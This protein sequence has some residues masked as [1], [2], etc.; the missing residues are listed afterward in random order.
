MDKKIL[1]IGDSCRDIF[2]YC[3]AERLCPD[4]PVPVLNIIDQTEN[5]GMA[6][7][8]QRNIQ[9]LIKECDIVTNYN[10]Y[11]ITKTRYMHKRT[12]HMFFRIDANQHEVPRINIKNLNLDYKIVVVSDYNKGFL[13]EEDIEYICSS[14]SA[15]FLDTK[16]NVG[17]F[18]NKALYIKINHHEYKCSE[19]TLT[20]KLANKI[21]VT[22]GDKGCLFREK[23]YP[24][25]KVQVWDLSGAGDSFMAGLVC[26]YYETN[27]IETSIIFANKCASKV[28]QERGVS[29]I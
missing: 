27:D 15:V 20:K 2:I 8:V 14:H 16:K 6:K 5:A 1:V 13:T 19:P 25:K 21:I 28:V 29:I 17:S 4:I 24:V 12:N 7:N 23:M 22:E 26:K 18:A 3:E 11:D 9:S 10:W